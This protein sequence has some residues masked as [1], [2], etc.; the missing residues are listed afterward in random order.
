MAFSRRNFLK[1]AAMSAGGTVLADTP[2][3]SAE[4]RAKAEGGNVKYVPTSCE[5]CFWKCGAVAKVV[6]GKVVK[7][8]GNPYH[9][10]S[11]GK[12]CARGQGG[13]GQLYDEDRLKHP[14]IIDGARGE[15]KYRKASWDEA[16]TLVAKK[17]QA[18][19]DKYGPESLAM[20]SHG[21]PGDY[22]TNVLK[23]M[24]SR[25]IAFPSFAQCK[26]IRD[27][28]WELTYGHKPG[29]SCERVDLE[30]SRVIVLFGTHLGENMHNSQN[31]EFAE[32][33]GRGAKIICVDPRYSTA[34]SKSS[35]W[36][37]IKP[38]TD[39]ALLLA[40]INIV[41]SEGLYDKEYVEKYTVGFEEVKEAVKEYTPEWA[42]Q[43]T[44]LPMRQIVESV[45][46]LCRYAPNVVVHPG[47]HYSWYGNDTQRARAVA[48]L[49]ALLGTWGRK[50]GMW[51]PAKAKFAK[52]ND[53][54]PAYPPASK[55]PL[56]KGDFPFAGGEGVTQVLRDATITGNPY[57]IKAWLVAGTNLMKSLPD[58]RLTRKAIDSLEFFVA[59]DLFPTETVMLADVILP[60][61]TYLERHDG[62]FKISTREA[63]VA[64]RQPAVEPMY[65]TKPAWWIGS[66][67]CKKLGLN[68]YAVKGNGMDAWEGRMRRQAKA[69]GLDYDQLAKH[70]GY[71]S[72]PDSEKPYI[73]E[74]NQPVFGTFSEKIELYSDELEG[75]GFDPVPKYE[76]VEHP[77]KGMFR[78]IYGRSPVHT[79]SR[80]VNTQWLWEL[81]KE[82]EVWLNKKEADRLGVKNGQYVVL[83]NQDGV[84]CN[85]IKA[86]VTERIRHDCVYMVHGFG[87]NAPRLKRA[88]QSGADDQ[89]LITK[90]IED[91]I[92]GGTGMR[93]NFVKI[94]KEA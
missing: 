5:M 37:P 14:M 50:G 31:Q 15:G 22:F 65:E 68:D 48:I 8:E 25:N 70:T 28:A 78:L 75:E 87:H 64:I 29:T 2:F 58:Q 17:M 11:R 85:K 10:Q 88:N 60:E 18:I 62:L 21:S 61:C 43:E 94:I 47:R 1:Y 30:N 71:V 93:V 84:R 3:I 7:L 81:E 32:A 13:I 35:F 72:I 59:I 39:T 86:K 6:D 19:A 76:P 56:I 36:L 83:E 9:P 80:T 90:Y 20:M 74:D 46:E 69:W 92:T 49:N 4:A 12:L 77:Q 91:P 52:F 33:V 42:A 16:L 34:A 38:G 79:F 54:A 51:L 73:T 55:P 66:E 40:W 41:I 67:L 53:D 27:V 82:N 44:E 23:A 89:K 24:G 26:G 63:G 57:P 45:R